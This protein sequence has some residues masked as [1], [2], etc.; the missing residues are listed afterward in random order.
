MHRVRLQGL[1]AT[2]GLAQRLARQMAPG[3]I[4]LIDGE[5]GAGK[6]TLVRSLVEAF[7]GDPALVASPTFTLCNQYQ[8]RLRVAHVDAYRLD[9][10]AGLVALGFDEQMDGGIGVV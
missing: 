1:E 8:A 2:K 4:L 7:G 6:T 10:P 9:G 5:L 3:D